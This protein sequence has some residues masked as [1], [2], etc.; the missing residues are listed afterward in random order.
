MG[1]FGEGE[2][3]V[4]LRVVFQLKESRVWLQNVRRGTTCS[5]WEGNKEG[6]AECGHSRRRYYGR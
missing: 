1:W 3:V 6:K 4:G 2:E 5:P